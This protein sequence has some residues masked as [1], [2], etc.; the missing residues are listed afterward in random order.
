MKPVENFAS[1][2]NMSF[3]LILA[4]ALLVIPLNVIAKDITTSI[5]TTS[6]TDPED[7]TTSQPNV[8]T[9]SPLSTSTASEKRELCPISFIFEGD[10][11]QQ[12]LLKEFR[13]E[14]LARHNKGITY[15][16]LYYV[17]SPEITL[18]L[19]SHNDIKIHAQKILMELLPVT[20]ALMND[21]A[22]EISQQLIDDIDAL[23]NEIAHQASS[24]LRE[25]IRMAKSDII[26]KEIFKEMD[27]TITK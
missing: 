3:S 25:A 2:K 18:I 5:A 10:Q 20:T 12:N 19:L 9:T 8:T 13:D 17:H 1:I 15:T 24:Q 4:V 16:R 27:M 6:L 22:A 11:H 7:T 14:V 21:G 23:L 26:K